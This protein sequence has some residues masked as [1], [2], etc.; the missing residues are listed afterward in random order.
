MVQEAGISK[1]LLFHYFE[2]KLGIYS[3]LYEYSVRFISL[4]LRGTVDPKQTDLFE[5]TKQIELAKMH[6][7]KAYPYMQQF[8]NRSMVE[9]VSEALLTIEHMRESLGDTYE[10]IY[11]QVDSETII[12]GTDLE[13]I[14]KILE[15]TS[16]GLLHE[17]F[18][19]ATFHPEN[20]YKEME[21]YIE[22]LRSRY[23]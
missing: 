3:F 20:F 7:M 12:P 4:E 2:N 13:K 16:Q 18:A 1:G 15:F 10:E 23:T 22:L 5:L 8:L 21:E 11:A 19:N 6:A 14:H 17:H 9:D